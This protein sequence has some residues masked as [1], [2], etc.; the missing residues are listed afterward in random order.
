[1]EAVQL[2][3]NINK[4]GL[5]NE[6]NTKIT[7]ELKA[8]PSVEQLQIIEENEHCNAQISMSYRVAELSINEIEKVVKDSGA[9]ITDI[10]I[11]LLTSV[12]GIADPYSAS[13]VSMTVNEK[14]ANI[15]GVLS[16]AISSRGELKVVLDTESSNKQTVIDETLKTFSTIRFG[17]P[18][19]IYKNKKS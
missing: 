4:P 12:T 11:H 1:M 6:W 15:D 5:N 18:Y 2:F 16:S 17:N 9:N 8:L 3:L 7:E 14:L 19:H 10:N 13:A